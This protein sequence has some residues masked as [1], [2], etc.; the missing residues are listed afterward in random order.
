MRLGHNP[1][2]HNIS[3]SRMMERKIFKDVRH[4]L[5]HAKKSY[6]PQRWR[7]DGKQPRAMSRA[8]SGR[9]LLQE[10]MR[11][12]SS[13]SL[14]HDDT[15]VFGPKPTKPPHVYGPTALLLAAS[16]ASSKRPPTSPTSFVHKLN[17]H[18]VSRSHAA[19]ELRYGCLP[20][21][22]PHSPNEGHHQRRHH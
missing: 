11:G 19:D 12:F 13:E 17:K 16:P 6:S 7:A 20:A 15:D 2:T 5:K 9:G 14:N 10:I 18:V 22:F 8:F 21:T 1:I 4:A 3:T